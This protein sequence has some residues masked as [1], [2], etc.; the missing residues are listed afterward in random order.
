MFIGILVSKWEE[1]TVQMGGIYRPNGRNLPLK[2]LPV[3]KLK[4]VM[5][6]YPFIKSI[7]SYESK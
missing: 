2:L 5:V 1:F 3:D 7:F 4:G 6:K